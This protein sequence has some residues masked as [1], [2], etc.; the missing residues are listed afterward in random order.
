MFKLFKNNNYKRMKGI[1]SC[2]CLQVRYMR[3]N[4]NI[5]IMTIYLILH[6]QSDK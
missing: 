4:N 1:T 2:K 6:I 5:I 3:Y